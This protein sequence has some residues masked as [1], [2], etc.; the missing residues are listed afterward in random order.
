ME[1]ELGSGVDPCAVVRRAEPSGLANGRP[2]VVLSESR[3]SGPEAVFIRLAPQVQQ[4]EARLRALVGSDVD[5][6]E[7][8]GRYLVV[9]GGKRLRPML[10]V[11]GAGV[12]GGVEF[13]ADFDWDMAVARVAA[14]D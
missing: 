13:G 8:V 9:A 7:A 11:L 6:V 14:E 5:V 10:T 4:G 2:G 3:I 12:L 1:C